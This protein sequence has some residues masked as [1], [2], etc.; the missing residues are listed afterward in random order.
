M[1]I[2]QV[3]VRWVLASLAG[4]I[5]G[6]LGGLLGIGLADWWGWKPRDLEGLAV[7]ALCLAS[8][9]LGLFIGSLSVWFRR[10]GPILG[11]ILPFAL[12]LLFCSQPN[13]INGR[14]RPAILGGHIGLLA[15]GVVS[16]LAGGLI[17]GVRWRSDEC[18]HAESPPVQ[19][20]PVVEPEGLITVSRRQPPPRNLSFPVKHD[21]Q[22]LQRE[23]HYRP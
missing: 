9:I 5:L 21:E 13:G 23:G 19:A 11:A 2:P 12:F 22:D 14:D 8:T 7:Y 17:G 20:D 6:F 4:G 3:F 18:P 15:A 10:G 1:T 16:G